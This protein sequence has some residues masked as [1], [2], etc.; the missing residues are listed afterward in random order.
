M[1]TNPAQCPGCQRPLGKGAPD[2]LCSACLLRAALDPGFAPQPDVSASKSDR[3]RSFGDFEL[4]EEVG[5][6]GMGVIHRA[7][8]RSLNRIVA[9]KL[10]L[11]GEWASPDFV[12]RFRTEAEAAAALEHPNIVPIHEVGHQEGQHYLAMKFVEGGSLARLLDDA[13]RNQPDAPP[14]PAREAARL[15]ATIGRAVQHAHDRGVLHRDLKPGNILIDRTGQPFLTDFGLAKLVRRDGHPSRT[16]AALG[17]PAYMAPEQASGRGAITTAVDVYGLAAVLYELLTGRPPF[18]GGTSFETIRRVLE[19]DPTAPRR[20]VP[21]LSRDLENICLRGLAKDPAR[22]YP[23]A[24]ALID[25]LER[26]LRGEPVQ[27]RPVGPFERAAKWARRNPA[28]AALVAVLSAGAVLFLIQR[29]TSRAELQ[30]ERDAALAEIRRSQLLQADRWIEENRTG[31][32]LAQFAAVLRGDPDNLIAAHRIISLMAHRDFVCPLPVGDLWSMDKPHSEFAPPWKA[33]FDATVPG[34]LLVNM[35]NHQQHL[36]DV[37]GLPYRMRFSTNRRWLA[38][39]NEAG[40]VQ[41]WDTATGKPAAPAFGEGQVNVLEFLPGD[42]AVV[43]AA[44]KSREVLVHD[45]RRANVLRR[46][47]NLSGPILFAEPAPDRRRFLIGGSAWAQIVDVTTGETLAGPVQGSSDWQST[48]WHPGGELIALGS[49]GARIE[50]RL[51][52]NLAPIGPVLQDSHS[53]Q[54]PTFT[55]DGL[56]LIAGGI[57]RPSPLWDW[58]RSNRLTEPC[59]PFRFATRFQF[60][61]EGATCLFHTRAGTRMADVRPGRERFLRLDHTNFVVHAEFS[62]DGRH[63]ATASFDGTARLWNPSTG[64][65]VSPPLEHA[66]RVR[67]AHFSPDSRL[68]ATVGLDQRFRLWSVPS[69]EPRSPW[70]PTPGVTSWVEFSRDGRQLLLSGSAGLFLWSMDAETP[71][72]L[73][74]YTNHPIRIA[75]LSPDGHSWA[76]VVNPELTIPTMEFHDAL[77]PGAPRFSIVLS[78]SSE[79]V[80]FSPDG[81]FLACSVPGSAAQVYRLPQGQ[82]VGQ[83]LLHDG[84]IILISWSHDGR[85][86]L[87]ASRDHTVRIWNSMSGEPVGQPLSHESEP[88]TIQWSPDDSRILTGT[89]EDVWR[90]WDSV[91]GLPLTEPLPHHIC[92]ATP[93]VPPSTSARFSPDGSR[94]VL[95]TDDHAAVVLEVPKPTL[96]IPRWLPDVAEAFAGVRFMP[97]GALVPVEDSKLTDLA[98]NRAGTSAGPFW[99]QWLEWTI[100]LRS[101]RTISPTSPI[102]VPLPDPRKLNRNDIASALQEVRRHPGNRDVLQAAADALEADPS[103]NRP[104]AQLQAR[105]I[106]RMLESR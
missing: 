43:T 32:A 80:D 40:K 39:A 52:T 94:I 29:A 19:H 5:R 14:Y 56:S 11:A 72:P 85:R 2:G 45:W 87:T 51:A 73:P 54:R 36:L 35:T 8:Q 41:I 9:L 27:A 103:T 7:R 57:N 77:R 47:E 17:T 6:G 37:D 76:A 46:I 75:H 96:P 26:W 99:D 48:G 59:L 49:T 69:G 92:V 55:P 68:V 63:I 24:A 33:G 61:G 1:L 44:W 70:L 31:D 100:Y 22:R 18:A 78:G 65:P 98:T 53:S 105:W 15:V 50:F 91:T 74:L 83:R 79:C 58:A 3:P 30:R 4:L 64:L 42:E 86:I 21:G 104:L 90:L 82:P 28:Q 20:L 16:V 10:I 67:S 23:S 13:Q 12:E 60:L 102:T 71:K 97:S 81:K 88:W 25:D 84:E 93:H 34:V 95:G 38:T 89:A 62:P 101:V 66:G 106:R